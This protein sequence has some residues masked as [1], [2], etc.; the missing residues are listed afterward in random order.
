MPLEGTRARLDSLSGK[1][2]WDPDCER[3]AVTVF[4]GKLSA[5]DRVEG[6][7][8]SRQAPDAPVRLSGRW[9]AE[10]R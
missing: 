10:R 4:E 8:T 5:P 7:F 2:D 9:A 6:T 3:R 1:W